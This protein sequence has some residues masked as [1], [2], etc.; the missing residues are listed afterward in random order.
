MNFLLILVLGPGLQNFDL[1]THPQAGNLMQDPI[2]GSKPNVFGVPEP[3]RRKNH[4]SH[5]FIIYFRR[6]KASGDAY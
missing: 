3:K 5:F 6:R 1:R 2:F 4:K